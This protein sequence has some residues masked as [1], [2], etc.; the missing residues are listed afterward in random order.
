MRCP[1]CRMPLTHVAGSP[2]T[3]TCARC[4]RDYSALSERQRDVLEALRGL[5]GPASAQAIADALG[6][7]RQA[8]TKIL[9]RLE[10]M[11]VVRD[12]PVMV[13]SG[14]WRVVGR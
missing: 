3:L 14:K 5:D 1:H 7:S 10:T 4:V 2:A 12:E 9:A 6:I 11:G 8:A 13:R